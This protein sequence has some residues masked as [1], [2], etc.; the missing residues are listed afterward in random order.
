V[1]SDAASALHIGN[2][3]ADNR[4]FDG[5]IAWVRISDEILYTDSFT[6]PPLYGPPALVDAT[7]EQWDLNEGSH[8]I[9][10]AKNNALTNDGT[11]TAGTWTTL[12]TS[13]AFDVQLTVALPEGDEVVTK[14][15]YITIVPT[16][17]E[18][19]NVSELITRMTALQALAEEVEKH[20]GCMPD[21]TWVQEGAPNTSVYKADLSRIWANGYTVAVYEDGA[22]LTSRASVAL[23]QANPGSYYTAFRSPTLSVYIHTTGSDDPGTN[24]SHYSLRFT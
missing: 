7:V 8:T 2:R 5:G 15:D 13:Y 18:P 1:N 6:P 17:V 20:L 19:D 9:A 16:P 24:S 23:C 22:T 4:A 3:V 10:R 11:I 21:A 14:E 12:S